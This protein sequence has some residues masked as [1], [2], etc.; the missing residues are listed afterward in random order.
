MFIEPRTDFIVSPYLLECLPGCFSCGWIFLQ[1]EFVGNGTWWRMLGG[2][3]TVTVVYWPLGSLDAVNSIQGTFT[4]ML[5]LRHCHHL[6]GW[7]HVF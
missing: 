3:A 7:D 4:L 5:D 2:S 6:M 1:F